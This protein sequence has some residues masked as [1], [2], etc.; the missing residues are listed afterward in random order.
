MNKKPLTLAIDF[1]GVIHDDKHPLPGKKMG[2]PIMGAKIALM[3]LKGRGCTII[4]HTV[5]ATNPQHV[6][7]WLDYYEIPYDDVT[8]IK[9]VAD[10]YLDDKAVTF[11]SWEEIEI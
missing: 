2:P 4:V 7:D 11:T 9:P 5:R 8:N 1:D 6:K 10:V 3:R